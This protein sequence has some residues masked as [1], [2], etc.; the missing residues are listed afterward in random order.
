MSSLRSEDRYLKHELPR[1]CQGDILRD[2]ELVEWGTVVGA[3][4]EQKITL[5]RRRLPYAVVLSQECDLYQDLQN[6]RNAARPTQDKYLHS[7]LLGPAYPA[8][9]VRE[10][11]HLTALNVKCE[12]LNKNRWNAVQQNNDP[13][14]HFLPAADAFQVPELVIDFKHFITAPRG[15][16]LELRTGAYLTSLNQLFRDSLSQRFAH[17]LARV[18]L[19]DPEEEAQDAAGPQQAAAG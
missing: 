5:T 12:P 4:P 14:Y 10:G 6:R 2:L 17:F 19:P 7:V 16:L 18:A 8:Q 1:L 15:V 3:E 11:T 9:S 13:R